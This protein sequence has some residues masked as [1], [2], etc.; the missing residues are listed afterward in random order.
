MTYE[1]VS[2]LFVRF[3][4]AS[5]WPGR[6]NPLKFFFIRSNG[7]ERSVHVTRDDGQ[8]SYLWVAFDEVRDYVEPNGKR[9]SQ[10]VYY[11]LRRRGAA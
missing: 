1:Q 5:I 10:N 9:D 11:Q 3:P 4:K 6:K 7:N 2:E 8:A